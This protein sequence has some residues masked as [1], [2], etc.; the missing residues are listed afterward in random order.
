MGRTIVR[1]MDRT[2][3]RT[4][5]RTLDRSGPNQCSVRFIEAY[6]NKNEGPHTREARPRSTEPRNRD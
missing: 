4:I 6:M 3:D 1:T 2:V 5:V